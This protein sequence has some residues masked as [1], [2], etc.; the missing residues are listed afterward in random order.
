MFQAIK[1]GVYLIANIH[2]SKVLHANQDVLGR[3]GIKLAGRSEHKKPDSQIWLI[4]GL[5]FM[6]RTF[7]YTITNVRTGKLLEAYYKVKYGETIDSG[8]KLE[9]CSGNELQRWIIERRMDTASNGL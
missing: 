5:P 6:E 3:S 4:E 2:T 7:Q 1:P 8:V 9:K